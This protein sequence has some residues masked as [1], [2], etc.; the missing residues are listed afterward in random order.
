M[1]SL[2]IMSFK[3]KE[4]G[5]C[6]SL[7]VVS[8]TKILAQYF[9]LNCHLYELNRTNP[10][11]MK[12]GGQTQKY[13][14]NLKLFTVNSWPDPKRQILNFYNLKTLFKVCHFSSS[15]KSKL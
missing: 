9:K 11:G 3:R 2:G 13:N 1:E 14:L 12:E 5:N 4:L 15:K 10:L 7:Q 6:L 8:S